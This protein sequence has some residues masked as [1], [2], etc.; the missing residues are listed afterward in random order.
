[1]LKLNPKNRITWYDYFHHP[2]FINGKYDNNKNDEKIEEKSNL[3]YIYKEK[4]NEEKEN[5]QKKLIQRK[6][7]GIRKRGKKQIF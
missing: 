5:E 6:P 4:E 2:F 3:K 7:R 1:M